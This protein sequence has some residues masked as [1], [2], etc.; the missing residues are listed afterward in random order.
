MELF[1]INDNV[2]YTSY[3]EERDRPSL[4]LVIGDKYT[5]AIDAGHSKKHVEEFYDLIKRHN[6]TLPDMT[7]LTHYHWDH[8][9][10]IHNINGISICEERT[11]NALKKLK[12]DKDY[13]EYLIKNDIHVA[14]E[15]KDQEMIIE[16]CDIVYKDNIVISLGNL[17]IKA[18]HVTSSHCEDN[19]LIYIPKYKILFIGDSKSG[20]Y[21]S[22]QIDKEKHLKYIET[23][24][25][26]DFEI[27][28]GG[29]WEAFS[30]ETLLDELLD[31]IKV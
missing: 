19:N 21:P 31:D 12:N 20:I 1:K 15:Y 13:L 30:K 4:G 8:S 17:D 9:F 23:I 16:E 7:I 25:E 24:K 29:H 2:W 28:I 6:L 18:F 10:G 11:N 14:L 27:A 5:L 22:W 26:I 3:E